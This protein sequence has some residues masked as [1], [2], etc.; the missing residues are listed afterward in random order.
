MIRDEF[1]QALSRFAGLELVKAYESVSPTEN[2]FEL[3]VN[4]ERRRTQMVRVALLDDDTVVLAF[5]IIGECPSDPK[6][7]LSL[8]EENNDGFYSKISV[9]ENEL[10]QLYKYPLE[11]LESLEMAKAFDEV[12]RFADIYEAKYF[13]GVDKG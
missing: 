6:T 5:S 2:I 12:S 10:V 13:G 11:E 1:I 9:H 4:D 8:L 3:Y 7:L